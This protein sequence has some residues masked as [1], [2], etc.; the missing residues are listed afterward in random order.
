MEGITALEANATP[1]GGRARF[2]LAAH[3]RAFSPARLLTAP[4]PKEDRPPEGGEPDAPS[5]GLESPARARQ[6]RRGEAG[7]AASL[8]TIF[9]ALIPA[10]VASMIGAARERAKQERIALFFG[11]AGPRGEEAAARISF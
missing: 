6:A 11:P 1:R 8:T 5:L 10:S 7:S 2:T 3:L 4:P 9:S